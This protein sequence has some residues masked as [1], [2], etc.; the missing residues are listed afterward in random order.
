MTTGPLGQDLIIDSTICRAWSKQ[1][2]YCAISYKYRNIKKRFGERVHTLLDRLSG[3]P[4]MLALSPANANDTPFALP[5]LQ[6]AQYFWNFKI[7]IVRA[8]AA[9]LSKALWEYVVGRLGAIWAVDYNLRR[10]GKKHLANRQQMQHWRWFLRPRATI[11][12]FFAWVKR[13]YQ[14]KYFKVQGHSALWRHVVAT[15]IATLFVGGLAMQCKQAD[16][17]HSPSRVLAYFDA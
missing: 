7:K 4:V 13:Y 14:L 1:D 12:R 17:M 5:L 11:E 9:Y 10:T 8:D 2:P 16:L 15:Y 3:L 6:A